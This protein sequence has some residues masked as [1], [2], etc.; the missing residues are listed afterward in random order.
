M[1]RK[2]SGILYTDL[3]LAMEIRMPRFTM[4]ALAVLAV[5]AA[6]TTVRAWSVQ[7]VSPSAS[8]ASRFS[9]PDEQVE[10]MTG[11][12]ESRDTDQS[13]AF[14][15][16]RSQGWSLSVNP[17]GGSVLSP[18]SPVSPMIGPGLSDRQR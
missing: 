8:G 6:P 2:S 9:D 15:G 5:T 10:Q 1:I 18:L 12:S 3:T 7:D 11:R 17:Q 16:S 14:F 4:L 13:R